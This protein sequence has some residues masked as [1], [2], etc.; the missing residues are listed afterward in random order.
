MIQFFAIFIWLIEDNEE[1]RRILHTQKNKEDESFP[2]S[3][4]IAVGQELLSVVDLT[5]VH[6]MVQRGMSSSDERTDR[7]NSVSED[8]RRDHQ[9]RRMEV[10]KTHRTI[11]DQTSSEED[12]RNEDKH[13]NDEPTIRETK[14]VPSEED[15]AQQQK[16]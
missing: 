4:S 1:R 6:E 14:E 7:K 3:I 15:S 16:E 10:Q 12:T 9:T 11:I 8:Q 13:R 2:F 5:V